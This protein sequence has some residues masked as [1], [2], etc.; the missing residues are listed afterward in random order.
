M[1]IQE[2]LTCAIQNIQV[3]I[4]HVINPKKSVGIIAFERITGSGRVISF[5]EGPL[6][7]RYSTISLVAAILL[8]KITGYRVCLEYV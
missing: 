2:Y 8:K 6:A 5:P 7:R 1:K 3:L 4:K